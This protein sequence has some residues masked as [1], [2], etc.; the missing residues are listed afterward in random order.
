MW[1]LHPTAS[2]RVRPEIPGTGLVCSATLRTIAAC[3]PV[4]WLRI[5]C[6]ALAEYGTTWGQVQPDE[7]FRDL[8]GGQLQLRSTDIALDETQVGDGMEQCELVAGDKAAL[9]HK[10]LE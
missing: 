10:P 6:S 4:F 2:D 1:G 7:L 5:G 8:G 3:R 9:V